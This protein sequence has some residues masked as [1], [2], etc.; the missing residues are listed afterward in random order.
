MKNDHISVKLNEKDKENLT[1]ISALL[2]VPFSQIVREAINEKVTEL[3]RSHPKLQTE[4]A[5]VELN[6]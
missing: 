5:R 6:K 2:D 1:E 4:T 3:K